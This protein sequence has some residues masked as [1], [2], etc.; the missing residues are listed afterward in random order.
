MYEDMVDECWGN[1]CKKD[2]KDPVKMVG[3]RQ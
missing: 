3:L 1:A 2:L